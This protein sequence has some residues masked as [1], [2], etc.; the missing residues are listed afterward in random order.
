MPDLPGSGLSARQTEADAV[1]VLASSIDG[2][3]GACQ[4]LM[5][6]ITKER[7]VVLGHSMG[8]YVA[9]C[10]AA[11]KEQTLLGLGLVNST[12]FADSN[13]KKETRQKGMAFMLKNG[14]YAFLRTSIP[15]L[16]GKLFAQYQ[17]ERI[18]A[19]VEASKT[20][21]SRYAVAY[22][23]AMMTRADQSSL[24]TKL[25]IPVLFV[26]GTEDL[27]APKAD[28][29]EQAALPKVAHVKIMQDVGHM[30]M[31][32]ATETLNQT[33]LDFLNDCT[34]N[35]GEGTVH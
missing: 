23:R 7:F 28:V 1:A 10:M 32:E 20:F 33:L 34:A 12:A 4:A 11:Q 15:G 9:L 31:W 3:A 2:I 8:G 5:L 14:T 6:K 21:D 19:L 35:G 27:A 18:T 17:G 22:Y 26:M 16:F 24:L 25:E 29:L 13:A 30:S